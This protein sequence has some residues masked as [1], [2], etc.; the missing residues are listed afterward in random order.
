MLHS[1]HLWER[2]LT[3]KKK[4][5]PTKSS[6][7]IKREKGAKRLFGKQLALPVMVFFK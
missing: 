1:K 6:Y 2:S 3:L 5:P 7:F 4:L